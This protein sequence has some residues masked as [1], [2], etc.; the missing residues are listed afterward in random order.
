MSLNEIIIGA[1]SPIV[2]VCV[3]DEY[4][5]DSSEYCTFDYSTAAT[6]FGDDRPD[7]LLYMLSLHWFLPNGVNPLKKKKQ[8]CSALHQAGLSWPEVMNASD[9]DCQHYVFECE[10]SEGVEDA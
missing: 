2:P 7:V 10:W 9:E 1:V 5:G 3:P 8:I 4:D 6:L